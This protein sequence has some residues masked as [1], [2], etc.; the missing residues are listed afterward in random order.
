[1]IRVHTASRLHFGLLAPPS[2]DAAMWPDHDG[3][4]T[5]PRRRFGGVG[6]MVEKPG[7]DLTIEPASNWS[8]AGPLAERRSLSLKVSAAASASASR[9]R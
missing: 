8:A 9:F 7:I 3:A 5:L 2:A 1:M 6:L 4:P